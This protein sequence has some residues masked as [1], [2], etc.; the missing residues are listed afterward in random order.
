MTVAV[1]TIAYNF[2]IT[3]CLGIGNSW[4]CEE[5]NSAL[6]E[7]V[8]ALVFDDA[9]R[10]IN[11]SILTSLEKTEFA[12]ERIRKILTEPEDVE[13][14]QVGEA[15]AEAYLVDHRCCFFPWPDSRDERKHRSSLPGA[16]LVG[17]RTDN[18]GDV[19]AFGE[20]KTSSEAKYPPNVMYGQTGLK[21]QLEDLRDRE[22]IRDKLLV[23]LC[24]RASNAPW[25]PQFE[26]ASRRY[27]NN[28]SDV[29]LYGVLIRDVDPHVRDLRRRVES[30]GKN[31]PEECG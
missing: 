11:E 9:S 4:S 18:K 15:I 29:T 19:F 2:S 16:D 31:C 17:F 20:V 14:W 5:L 12:H 3:S 30:L 22:Q 7:D 8:A 25:R 27:L 23:Y 28:K 26:A 24:H 21:R 6:K 13:N 1:G 10:A